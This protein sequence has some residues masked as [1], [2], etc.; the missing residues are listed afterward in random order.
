MLVCEYS[1]EMFCSA[2]KKKATK[3]IGQVQ[4]YNNI[5]KE[6][7]IDKRERAVAKPLY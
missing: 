5:C 3:M 1:L 4:I 2:K 6:T 7:K